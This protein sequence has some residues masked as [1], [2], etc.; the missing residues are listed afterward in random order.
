M[1]QGISFL[2]LLDGVVMDLLMVVYLYVVESVNQRV[3]RI[4]ELS[5]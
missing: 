5:E 1:I 3:I 2:K 4:L